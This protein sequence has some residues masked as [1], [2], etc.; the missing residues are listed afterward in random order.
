LIG[1]TSGESLGRALVEPTVIALILAANGAPWGLE[2]G[3]GWML[4]GGC[5][6]WLFWWWFFFGGVFFGGGL[7]RGGVATGKNRV[8]LLLLAPWQ[9][10]HKNTPTNATQNKQPPSAS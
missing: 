3:G 2:V 7:G 6:W 5:W 9:H 8:D 4:V 1:A 10:I